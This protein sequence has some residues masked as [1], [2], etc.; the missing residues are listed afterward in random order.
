MSELIHSGARAKTNAPFSKFRIIT[1]DHFEK[2]WGH[3]DVEDETEAIEIAKRWST[4]A[5]QDY[6]VVLVLS[7]MSVAYRYGHE[8]ISKIIHP[9]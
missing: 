6:G 3:M 2:D 1:F 4:L 5:G 7:T 8:K 9:R